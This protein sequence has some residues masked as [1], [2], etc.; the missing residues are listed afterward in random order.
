MYYPRLRDLR[1]DGDYVQKE[2]VVSLGIDQHRL[3]PEAKRYSGSLWQ[4]AS[5]LIVFC[6]GNLSDQNQQQSGGSTGEQQYHQAGNPDDLFLQ[7]RTNCRPQSGNDQQHQQQ[8]AES[9]QRLHDSN[10]FPGCGAA[11]SPLMVFPTSR[12]IFSCS[13]WI[14]P[15]KLF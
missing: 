14:L 2:I 15:A 11:T 7:N 6:S 1:E 8:S 10:S 4:K 5:L 12:N 13:V 3:Y 9:N